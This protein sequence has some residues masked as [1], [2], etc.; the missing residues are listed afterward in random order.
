MFSLCIL[1]TESGPHNDFPADI[2]IYHLQE[3]TNVL[4]IV[5]YIGQ[6][7]DRQPL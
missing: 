6:H 2:S 7:D 5:A 4:I 1:V 3:M